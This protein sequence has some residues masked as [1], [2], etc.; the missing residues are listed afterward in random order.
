MWRNRFYSFINIL[1]LALGLASCLLVF[2]YA[3]Q[4]MSYD[5]FHPD[6]EQTFRFNL[7]FRVNEEVRE[8]P[9]STPQLAPA[10]QENF[11]EVEA[12]L[13]L[14]G[15]SPAI[16]AIE[17]AEGLRAFEEDDL[18]YADTNFFSFFNFPLLQGDKTT[19]LSKA[20]NV[21]L[22]E[23]LA[24]K[25]F[26]NEIPLH[27]VIG[28]R[29]LLGEAK[30]PLTVSAIAANAPENSHISFSLL[31]PLSTSKA[32]KEMPWGSAAAFTYV[33]FSP[34]FL[35]KEE[36]LQDFEQRLNH[37]FTQ[38][39]SPEFQGVFNRSYQ[40]YLEKGNYFAVYLIPLRDIYLHSNLAEELRTGGNYQ[41]LTL[42]GAIA[43]FIMLL[44]CVNFMNL[45]TARS[46]KRAKEVGVHK[47]LGGLRPQLARHFL[48]ESVFFSFLAL[49]L[50]YGMA[51]LALPTFNQVTGKQ[52][53]AIYSDPLL[54]G[55]SLL[56]CLLVGLAAGS[57]PAFYLTRF[58]PAQVIKG[59]TGSGAGN[60]RLRNA[61]VVFQFAIA[62]VL[63]SATFLI[64]QQ[65]RYMREKPLGF[66]KENVLV[67]SNTDML[68]AHFAAFKQEVEE[69]PGVQSAAYSNDVPGNNTDITSFRKIGESH[70]GSIAIIFADADFGQTMGMHLKAGRFLNEQIASDSAA[71]LINEAA[72]KRLGGDSILQQLI[73]VYAREND[74]QKVVGIVQDFNFRPLNK[75]VEPLAIL[76]EDRGNLL[77]V[78][79][80][81]GIAEK[82]E[83][84][85]GIWKE[86]VPGV[87]FEYSFLD[88]RFDSLLEA[89]KRTARLMVIFTLVAIFIACL[90]LFGLAAYT[91]EQR[92]KEIGVRKVL[93]SSVWEVVL[94]LSKDF[95]RLVLFSFVLAAPL[96]YL[97]MDYWLSHFAY[98]V[99][100]GV[101]LIALSGLLALLIAWLTVGYQSLKAALA[102]PAD[103]LKNE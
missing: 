4:E 68:G 72:A 18:L 23:R 38:K 51:E 41:S 45:A 85:E 86:T 3:K 43:F 36:R 99:P 2:V 25:Y 69:V 65:L 39:L 37:F 87:P 92:R 15:S 96:A 71:I 60:R 64:E 59:N 90:G 22:T 75:A 76:L 5:S 28:K 103:S 57:Y 33:K 55:F 74:Q 31:R 35:E 19:A 53:S 95:T 6:A 73:H 8:A 102:N 63:I 24:R 80:D 61:L 81:G 44:A 32:L 52:F 78:R 88:T 89:E 84:I 29:L 40:E 27:A 49:F 54:L 7:R 20:E 47:V 1:G 97:A 50:A 34:E 13:R 82:L 30:E 48:L 26:G 100:W 11:P 14:K 56:L 16:V 70:Q 77:S 58:V 93:G 94:L 17:A 10:L 46:A 62:I 91:A 101:G 21:V 79:M 67:I 83:A 98:Q 9:L 12:S 42:F 66:D